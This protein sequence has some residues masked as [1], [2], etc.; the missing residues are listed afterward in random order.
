[1]EMGDECMMSEKGVIRLNNWLG[2]DVVFNIA[3]GVCLWVHY[4]LV[5]K[6]S[7]V[8]NNHVNNVNNVNNNNNRV[9]NIN[10]WNSNIVPIGGRGQ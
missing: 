9:R 10:G 5:N 1:M 3:V 2:M 4:V 6:Y 8:R 7:R